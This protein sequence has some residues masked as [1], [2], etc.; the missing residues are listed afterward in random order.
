MA[1][2]TRRARENARRRSSRYVERTTERD[3]DTTA[4]MQ[5]DCRDAGARATQ[6]AVAELEQRTE[7]L[8]S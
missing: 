5:D 4:G 3:V 1:V 2:I 7:Q 6:G 8:P